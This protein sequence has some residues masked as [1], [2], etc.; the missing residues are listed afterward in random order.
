MTQAEKFKQLLQ[1]IVAFLETADLTEQEVEDIM[2]E[3]A[4]ET[5]QPGV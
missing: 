2:E 1:A 3:V 4:R 5:E